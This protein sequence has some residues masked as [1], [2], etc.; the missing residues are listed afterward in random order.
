MKRLSFSLAISLATLVVVTVACSPAPDPEREF[1]TALDA[2]RLE[3][4]N[5]LE[6]LAKR[7]PRTSI[8]EQM[9]EIG[10]VQEVFWDYVR[11]LESVEVPREPPALGYLVDKLAENGHQY[12]L[13]L[14]GLKLATATVNWDAF[15]NLE[16]A[17]VIAEAANLNLVQYELQLRS[18]LGVPPPGT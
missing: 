2:K 1:F 6:A 14:H 16:G 15:R 9:E 5:D 11:W 18:E 13:Y 7:P 12:G 3:V 17:R 4:S 10:Y 8:P